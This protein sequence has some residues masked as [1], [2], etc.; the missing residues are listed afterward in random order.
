MG[1]ASVENG[2]WVDALFGSE[3]HLAMHTG[4]KSRTSDALQPHAIITVPVFDSFD[5]ETR[6]DVATII[7]IM[8][9]DTFLVN[10]LP[11]GVNGIYLVIENTCDQQYTYRLDGNKVKYLGQGDL[12]PKNYDKDLHRELD[13]DEVYKNLDLQKSTPGACLYSY[14]LTPSDDFDA[15]FETNLPLVFALVVAGIFLVMGTTF[16]VYDAFVRRR[17][18]K[19]MGA[20]MRSTAIVTSLFPST[21]RERLYNGDGGAGGVDG[22]AGSSS[23]KLRRFMDKNGEGGHHVGEEDNEAVVLESKPIADLFPDTTVMFC[24]IGK[25]LVFETCSAELISHTKPTAYKF[26]PV[27]LQLALLLGVRCVN[28]LRSLLYSRLFTA[29]LIEW[30]N[31]AT[32]SKLRRSAIAMLPLLVVLIP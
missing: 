20:A 28:L 32:C 5:K 10:S 7:A 1:T 23:A 22:A 2:L 4:D 19:V 21:V 11:E 14:H 16:F 17:N 30:P 15:V 8:S 25:R 29:P 12:S 24:D 18:A 6:K 9:L 27:F 13:F 31:N 26:L 3:A